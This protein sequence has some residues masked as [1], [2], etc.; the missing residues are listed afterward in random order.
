MQWVFSG[1][2]DSTVPITGTKDWVN[3]YRTSY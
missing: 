3:K 1:D 2:M